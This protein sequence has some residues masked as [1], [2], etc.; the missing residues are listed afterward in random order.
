M[1]NVV[2]AEIVVCLVVAWLLGFLVAWILFK[3]A[4]KLYQEEIEQLEE[5]LQYSSACSKNQ[6]REII[7][8]ALTIQA[9]EKVN[10]TGEKPKKKSEEG[11]QQRVENTTRTPQEIEMLKS[12]DAN[13]YTV[14]Q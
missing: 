10:S 12:I 4:S 2:I 14:A 13:L 5:N 3:K 9:F 11:S 7:Q 8:Q 6:E 1:I